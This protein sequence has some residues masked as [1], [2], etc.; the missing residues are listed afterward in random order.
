MEKF[1]NIERKNKELI[2]LNPIQTGGKLTKPAQKALVEFGNGY[3][4]Y[5]ISP[6]LEI[7]EVPLIKEFIEEALPKFLGADIVRI[8]LGVREGI[9]NIMH[10]IIKPGETIL[11][12]GNRHYTTI[13]A[14]QRAGLKVVEVPSSGEPE[15]KINV[16][17]YEDL[18]K[19]HKPALVLLTYPD[20][21]YGNLPDAKKL[22][23]IAKKYKVPYLINGAY[24]VGRMPVSM[25]ELGADF[26]IGSG[27]KSMASSGPIGILGMDKKWEKTL[28]RKSK[29]YPQQEI[30]FLGSELRGTAIATLIAS[31]P[32]VLERVKNWEKEVE[33][34]QWFSKELEKLGLEQM[35]EKPHKHDLMFFKA[36]AFYEISLKHPR[37]RFFLYNALKKRGVTGI[38][39]GLTKYFKLSVFGISKLELKQVINAFKEILETA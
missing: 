19:K 20:G 15:Y 4:I 13:I 12:D 22:G 38:K 1:E 17:D 10:S 39:P 35:G 2:N 31:F 32:T 8:V 37:G 30:E 11:V 27:Q 34:A 9:F 3:S 14:A 28:L 25:K 6:G 7:M 21:N 33:K 36:D 26:I 23:R 16:E 5:D 18:I 24:T 29:I